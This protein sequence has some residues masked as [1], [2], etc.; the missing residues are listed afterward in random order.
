MPDVGWRAW[1]VGRRTYTSART[2]PEDLPDDGLLYVVEYTGLDTPKRHLHSGH[3]WYFWWHGPEGLVIGGN[4]DSLEENER[5]Y[6]G[7]VFVRGKWTT[8]EEMKRVRD[9]ALKAHEAP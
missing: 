7:A 2:A 9:A 5:R 8:H 1:Y 4:S 3:D 6:P